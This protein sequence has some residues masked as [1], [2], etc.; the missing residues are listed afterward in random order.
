MEK[1]NFYIMGRNSNQKTDQSEK[2][3][4]LAESGNIRY[5]VSVRLIK[6][7]IHPVRSPSLLGRHR[8]CSP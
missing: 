4:L 7:H 5:F 6:I 1:A 2:S 8:Q 3:P